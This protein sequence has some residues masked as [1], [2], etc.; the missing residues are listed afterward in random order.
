MSPS[1]PCP[2]AFAL[3]Q[4]EDFLSSF[5]N[6]A[7]QRVS[8][9]CPLCPR[10]LSAV[11]RIAPSYENY[12]ANGPFSTCLQL[13][14]PL[15]CYGRKDRLQPLTLGELHE[16]YFVKTHRLRCRSLGERLGHGRSRIPVR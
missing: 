6:E 11:A 9:D 7:K 12:L 3:S 1:T 8:N 13:A 14:R 4:T 15:L 5:D 16:H 2:D 10:T